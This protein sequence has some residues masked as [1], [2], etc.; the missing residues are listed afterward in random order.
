MNLF[1]RSLGL[2]LL[3]GLS[4][5]TPAWSAE[6][7]QLEGKIPLGNV[8]GRIDHFAYDTKRQRLFVAELGNNSVGIVDLKTGK[9]AGRLQGLS[10]PQGVA[11]HQATETLY[12]ANAGDGSVRLYQA[13]RDSDFLQP[14]GAIALGDD[15]DN[16]RLDKWRERIVV[17]YGKGALAMIDPAS[18]RKIADIALRGHPESFQFDEQGQRIFANV[19]DARQIAVVDVAAGKQT[20]RLDLGG[21]H[22]N[23][24]M[25]V[26]AE[27]HRLLIATRSPARLLAF[28]TQDGKQVASLETC[29]DSDDLF[30]DAR[31]QRVYVTCGE[32]VVEVFARRGGSYESIGRVPTV[33]GA[34]TSWFAVDA[35]RLYVGV[36]ASG[37]EPA[38]LWIFRPAP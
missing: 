19:P 21:A 6:P 8:S 14:A 30:I 15:A 2:A 38:A 20:S 28:A 25:A 10:E 35:D 9:V 36:R 31:R 3:A 17:G 4:I 18:R 23:F 29:R 22:S 13:Y 32:G 16:I 26:D 34:R 7:L 24:P 37:S 27:A 5:A 12:V 11:Y 1:S 33:S